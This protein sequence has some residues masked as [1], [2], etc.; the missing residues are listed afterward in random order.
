MAITRFDGLPWFEKIVA[1]ELAR[2]RTAI[3]REIAE[4][5][6]TFHE[7]LDRALEAF[8]SIRQE[9]ASAEQIATIDAAMADVCCG[10]AVIR[11]QERCRVWATAIA[12]LDC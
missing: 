7:E 2:F 11:R 5:E 10:F 6:Q 8:Q 4:T 3:D 12:A 1:Q 9:G